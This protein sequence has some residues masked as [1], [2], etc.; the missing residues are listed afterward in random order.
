MSAPPFAAQHPV[1]AGAVPALCAATPSPTTP[2]EP[3]TTHRST[4]GAELTIGAGQ[5][6]THSRRSGGSTPVAVHRVR[7]TTAARTT[8]GTIE[9]AARDDR[10]DGQRDHSVAH[11]GAATGMR[12][13]TRPDASGPWWRRPRRAATALARPYAGGA[14][15]RIRLIGG[16]LEVA[17][18]P[19]EIREAHG[20]PTAWRRQTSVVSSG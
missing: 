17:R 16:E 15:M 7:L 18:P 10:G 12:R 9:G 1:P 11:R 6:W 4:R 3:E 13:G 14:S 20:A 19:S 5:E 8:T 2:P